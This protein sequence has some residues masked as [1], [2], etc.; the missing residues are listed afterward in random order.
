MAS[1]VARPFNCSVFMIESSTLSLSYLLQSHS[2]VN[3]VGILNIFHCSM[4]KLDQY[5]VEPWIYT[6]C[7]MIPTT[8]VKASSERNRQDIC[9]ILRFR[10]KGFWFRFQRK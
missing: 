10:K 8:T 5:S 7:M 3:L 2:F 1:A 6:E 4:H 9:Q